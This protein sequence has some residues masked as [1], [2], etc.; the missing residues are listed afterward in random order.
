[1]NYEELNKLETLTCLQGQFVP[2]SYCIYFSHLKKISLPDT[3]T[4][5]DYM[6]FSVTGLTEFTMPS[7]LQKIDMYAFSGCENLEKVILNDKLE[8]IETRAFAECRKLQDVVLPDS[9]QSIGDG[10]FLDCNLSTI[11]IPEHVI[12][13]KDGAFSN[14]KQ[15]S[16]IVVDEHNTKYASVDGIKK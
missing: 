9:L 14:N 8:V 16:E 4:W 2:D 15:L 6:A 10:V 7:E 13:I 12:L 3:V 5:I 1:V 11:R